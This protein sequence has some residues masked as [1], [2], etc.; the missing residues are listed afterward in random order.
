MGQDLDFFTF[1]LSRFQY[2]GILDLMLLGR[3]TTAI[4][5]ILA[6]TGCSDD[7][8]QSQASPPPK[9]EFLAD[10]LRV[11]MGELQSHILAERQELAIDRAQ[12]LFPSQQTLAMACDFDHHKEEY[13]LISKWIEATRPRN[14]QNYLKLYPFRPWQTEIVVNSITGSELASATGQ[15]EAFHKR[16]G[17]LARSGLLLSNRQF[18]SVDFRMAGDDSG[19]RYELFVWDSDRKEW[20]MLGPIWRALERPLAD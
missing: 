17:D 10:N 3:A 14:R 18:F 15:S 12:S 5:V 11:F 20:K 4:V 13:R 6:A 9:K 7:R 1:T 19:Q 16:A 2:D 8:E